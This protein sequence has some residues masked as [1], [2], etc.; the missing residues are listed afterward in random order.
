MDGRW[1]TP[2][3]LGAYLLAHLL[4]IVSAYLVNP[5]LFSAL[6]AAGHRD[7]I[8]VVAFANSIV[9]VIAVLILFLIFRRLFR[10]EP[11]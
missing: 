1:T 10:G 2:A 8:T 9:T 6:I 5:Y 11:V 4:G 7:S 3:E